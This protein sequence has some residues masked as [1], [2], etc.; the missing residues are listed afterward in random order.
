MIQRCF[1]N[2]FLRG[3][4]V[5]ELIPVLCACD[6]IWADEIKKEKHGVTFQRPSLL[7][8]GDDAATVSALGGAIELEG[9]LASASRRAVYAARMPTARQAV[10]VGVSWAI[11]AVLNAAKARPK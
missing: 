7:S 3:N 4:Q 11:D 5:P 9:P 2:D 1:F 8:L 10:K 6:N